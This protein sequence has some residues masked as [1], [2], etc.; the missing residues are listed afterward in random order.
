MNTAK[1][2]KGDTPRP[3]DMETYRKSHERIFGKRKLV[4][5]DLG[6]AK[7]ERDT[8]DIS[9]T[10]RHRT[11]RNYLGNGASWARDMHHE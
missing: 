7:A 11:G 4:D 5:I 6:T 10:P 1:N 3:V 8:F 2:G 9:D